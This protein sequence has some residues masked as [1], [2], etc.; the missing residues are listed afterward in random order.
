[1]T[2]LRLPLRR[3][4]WVSLLL[5]LWIGAGLRLG[6]PGIT[7]FKRDEAVLTR[8]ALNL[9]Q[10][11]DFPW[12]GMGS[13]TGFPNTPLSVYLLAL[14]MTL[15][16]NPILPTV[17]I[18]FLNLL[19][20]ALL[21]KFTRRY[22]GRYAALI[23]GISFA[24][25]PWAVVYSRKIWAQDML[26]PFILMT[27][28]TGALGFLENRPKRWAQLLHWPFLAITAQI[29][30]AGLALILVS[31]WCV[32]WGRKRLTRSFW[33]SLAVLIVLGLPFLYGLYQAEWLSRDAL[34]SA[35]DHDSEH[36]PALEIT[37][38][39]YAWFTING[40]NL[41]SMT[42]PDA[43]EAYLDTLPSF[44]YWLMRLGV[45]VGLVL[46]FSWGLRQF[47]QRQIPFGLLMMWLFAPILLFTYSWTVVQ[48]HYFIPLLPPACILIGIGLTPYWKTR[49]V[50]AGFALVMVLQA[51]VF[52]QFLRFVSVNHTPGAFGTPLIYQLAVRDEI[53]TDDPDSV[54]VLTDSDSVAFAES[55]AVWDVL[56]AD[57]PQVR[58][59]QADQFLIFP[60]EADT[61]LLTPQAGH[62]DWLSQFPPPDTL[63]R[64]RPTEGAYRIWETW[65]STIPQ[66]THS[67]EARLANGLWLEGV[68]LVS[69]AENSGQVV[70]VWRVESIPPA[71]QFTSFVH[72]LTAE[73]ARV[74]QVDLPFW[75]TKYWRPGDR[76]IQTLTLD[77]SE[78]TTL[79][80]GMYQL[81]DGSFRNAEV[82]DADGRYLEQFVRLSRADFL[83]ALDS[84]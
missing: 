49:A 35:L 24:V 78:V 5:V 33:I 74:V 60:A 43:F 14:P 48:P 72:G 69:D 13:S 6:A 3:W 37:A 79:H 19:A 25:S 47:R 31:L 51:W 64:L 61:A 50:R 58:F 1:M 23:A 44:S 67:V 65:P 34:R 52:I 83:T 53:L 10:G 59:V 2:P 32:W 68:Q 17:F 84:P 26:A 16:T 7:E 77:L 75:P 30:F 9:A 73:E 27:V 62:P 12:L 29:H 28:F 76:I 46:G 21:W 36:Q 20:L 57:V 8:L 66:A 56:L 55:P 45:G 42:G 22:W 80:I 15:G 39:E 4:E 81:V 63:V 70:L 82:L 11:H 40:T 71:S 41:H 54:L 18:G 38:L